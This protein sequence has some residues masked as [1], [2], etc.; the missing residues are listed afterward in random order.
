VGREVV[1]DL[2]ELKPIILRELNFFKTG[3]SYSG[4]LEHTA[5]RGLFQ[6]LR[7]IETL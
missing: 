3:G 6:S 5:G 1:T 4:E 7:E 2:E